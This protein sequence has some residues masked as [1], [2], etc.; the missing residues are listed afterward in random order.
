[1]RR[2]IPPS[3]LFLE[4][5]S[6]Y[7]EDALWNDEALFSEIGTWGM[8]TPV[9]E[10]LFDYWAAREGSALL[11]GRQLELARLMLGD[12]VGTLDE[13]VQVIQ[14]GFADDPGF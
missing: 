1:M 7:V 13:L 9:L 10:V 14:L 8:T 3:E 12:F 2:H 11:T 6:S 5:L 4:L